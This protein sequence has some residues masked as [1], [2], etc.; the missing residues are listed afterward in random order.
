MTIISATSKE[1]LNE[2]EKR[3]QAVK[4][5]RAELEKLQRH[6]TS[7]ASRSQSAV[8]D[9]WRDIAQALVPTL[10]AA[11]LDARAAALHMPSLAPAMVAQRR[12]QTLA[13]AAARKQALEND[14]DV[15][16]SEALLNEADIKLHELNDAIAPL[17]ASIT[18]LRAAPLFQELLAHRYGTPDYGIRFWQ[19]LY[20]K[21]WKHADLVVA[22]NLKRTGCATFADL[23]KRYV[24]ECNAAE[25]LRND[26]SAWNR[27]TSRVRSK[28]KQRD[29]AATTITDID[30][31]MLRLTQ[32]LVVEHL[33]PLE[34]SLH[35]RLAFS[36]DALTAFRRV[37]G[38]QKKHEY[39]KAL[40]EQ[41]LKQAFA[42]LKR[43]EASIQKNSLKLLRPKNYNRRW[44][45]QQAQ[46]FL[47]KDRRESWQ[48][49]RE[50]WANTHTQ[51]VQFNDYDRYRPMRDF[52]WWD[53]MTDGR[54]DGNFVPEVQR[55]GPR[56]SAA[57]EWSDRHDRR[58][59][60][61]DADFDVS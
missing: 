34:D 38:L 57:E 5:E 7:D 23:A 10:D 4:D 6:I 48:K 60:G 45:N 32:S 33:K 49:K 29:E 53:V 16:R 1:L 39:L 21:H 52:L 30:N 56:R 3:S 15:I 11:T 28:L 12:L 24:N 36:P 22:A 31:I 44:Y 2:L 61:R 59:A 47:G 17:E 46:G 58:L 18:A 40:A 42:D 9:A 51:I 19:M 8:H 43:T 25:Q 26:K 55:R 14:D 50:R 27:V 54:L 13:Q 20:Y 41:P 37:Q 35:E